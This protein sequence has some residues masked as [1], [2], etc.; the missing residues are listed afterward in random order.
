MEVD[1]EFRHVCKFCSKSFACGRSLG[2]HMRSHMIDDISAQADG[3]KITKKKLPPLNN[4]TSG[5]PQN[6]NTSAEL[7]AGYGLRENPKK[8]WRFA[9]HS[10]EDTSLLEKSCRECGKLFPSWKSLFGHMKCHST[11]KERV[12]LVSTN[13]SLEEQQDS[14]TSANNQKLVVDSQSDNETAA[15]SRRKRSKRRI[16]YMV[17]ANS[18]SL[19]FANNASS[20]VSEIEQEQEEVAMCL[21]L[22]SRDVGQW[23]GPNS[24]AESSDNNSAFLESKT[25]GKASNSTKSDTAKVK[26]LHD[27]K[28]EFE[29]LIIEGRKTEFSASA[30][31]SRLEHLNKNEGGKK[32]QLDNQCEVETRKNLT[33]ETGE[34]TV[35][36]KFSSRK[37]KSSNSFDP[38]LESDSLRKL[39][40]NVL[41]DPEDHKDSERSS[42]FECATCNKVFHSYQ[43]LGGHRAS[44]KKMKGCFA[45]RN[46][47]SENSIET[48]VSPDPT[49][50]VKSINN[51][52]PMDH[53]VASDCDNKGETSYGAKKSKGHEC[54]ICLRVFPTGQALGG[55]KRSHLTGA[56]EG[57]TNMNITS[58]EPIPAIRGFLD[59]N[60]P[61]PD[62]EQ[63][64]NGVVGFNPWWIGSSHKHEA[65][66]GLISN[67]V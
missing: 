47:S 56:T 1:R 16:R 49:A 64:S 15:P 13:N 62:E 21:M 17:T 7:T 63:Q 38:E 42:K 54:A 61:A 40:S 32:T 18:S 25:E 46:D 4:N 43:A 60:L 24:V 23:G 59:L 35:P 41:L 27:K 9:D 65:L 26:K 6:N 33:E 48:E 20:S 44:H 8:T 55:H 58:Q 36:S 39:S 51:D 45:S 52:F 29:E 14:W 53:L 28:L 37:R 57:K 22:L 67:R 5:A 66:V 12:L 3:T 30:I 10:S 50:D 19:S 11:E 31:S 2:G 34:E